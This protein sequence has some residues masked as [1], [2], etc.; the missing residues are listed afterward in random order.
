[1][2]VDKATLAV[3]AIGAAVLAMLTFVLGVLAATPREQVRD[4]FEVCVETYTRSIC[5]RSFE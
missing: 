3:C 1:V 2:T 5:E 4:P